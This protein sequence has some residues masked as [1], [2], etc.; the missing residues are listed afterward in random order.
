MVGLVLEGNE[1]GYRFSGTFG[2]AG[3]GASNRPG[4]A[5]E[6]GGEEVEDRRDAGASFE[7]DAASSRSAVEGRPTR[8]VARK[9]EPLSCPSLS[10]QIWPPMRRHRLWLMAR[11]RPGP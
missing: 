5:D 11:P 1:W 10:A 9:V 7:V 3:D 6:G 2:R 4:P 8:T